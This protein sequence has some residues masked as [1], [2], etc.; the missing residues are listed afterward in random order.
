VLIFGVLRPGPTELSI[1]YS[2]LIEQVEAGNVTAVTF[3][4]RL[5]SGTFATE[6]STAGDRLLV[7]GEPPPTGFP[8]ADV[9]V[10]TAFATT[11]PTGAETSLLPLLQQHNVAIAAEAAENSLGQRLVELLPIVLP[12]LLFVGLMFYLGRTVTRGQ[13]R[14]L[15]IQRSRART[16]D[17]QRPQVTFADIAGADEAKAELTQ[18]VD[19]LRD[20]P[21]YL[22]LGAHLPHGV[23]LLGPPGTGKTLLARAVAGEAAVPFFS[24][25]ASEFVELYV[26]VGA[27]RVRDLF[28]QAKA[29]APA[30]VFVDEL[31]AVGRQRF[32][33]IGAGNEEREQ[34]LNQLLVELDGFERHEQVI[35]LAATNRPDVLDP[36]LLRPGRFDRQVVLGLPDRRGREAILRLHARGVPLSADVDPAILAAETPGFAGADLANL[37]NEAALLAA[38]RNKQTVDRADFESALDRVVLGA[39]RPVLISKG[40]QRLLAYHEAGH[41]V[42]A[43]LIPGADPLRKISIVPHGLALGVTVQVP[44]EE[45]FTDTRTRL[46][47][48]LA[49]MM[50]G[51]AAEDLVFDE[52]TTGAQR[53]LEE[54]TTLARQMVGLWGMS[55]EVGPYF[56]GLGE[57][58]AFLGREQATE[59]EIS[60]AM[61]DR[62]EAAVQRLLADALERARSLLVAHRSE[63]DRL[64]GRLLAEETLEQHEI[65]ALLGAAPAAVG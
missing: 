17:P 50:G 33:G 22:R 53:D 37:V 36:A 63:L 40:E 23:L 26:G 31:D 62:A 18:I 4:D 13:E 5:V 10:G 55:D 49:T 6:M 61:L 12:L 27:S 9:K 42:V 41:A 14:I 47:G 3:R 43:R 39:E 57:R 44:T 60:E 20:P 8:P 54:A 32:L 38:R 35:V 2:A 51:R 30:I 59:R 25:S 7:P 21:K 11:I 15:G 48:R 16:A 46:L 1:T 34:T 45:R 28:A 64:A 24:I 29:A 19:F 65:D 56:L 52:R 58:H